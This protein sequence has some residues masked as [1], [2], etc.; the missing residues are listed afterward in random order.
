MIVQKGAMYAGLEHP[1]VQSVERAGHQKQAIAQIAKR[2]QSNARITRPNPTAT[3]I[4][5]IKAIIIIH[6]IQAQTNIFII[7]Y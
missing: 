1:A 2:V 4:F 6:T 3:A 7:A 5:K